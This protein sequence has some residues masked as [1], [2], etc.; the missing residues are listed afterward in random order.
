MLKTIAKTGLAALTLAGFISTAQATGLGSGDGS[1]NGVYVGGHAGGAWGDADVTS[2]AVIF[3]PGILGNDTQDSFDMDGWLAGAHVGANVQSGAWV[4]GGELSLSAAGIDGSKTPCAT[5]TFAAN[6]QS[7]TIDHPCKKDDEW[8]ALAM[9][10]FGYAPGNWMGYLTA[11]VAVVGAQTTN[12]QTQSDGQIT[13][14]PF[15]FIA[16]SGTDVGFAI[17]GG[18]EV[19]L[20][21]G[22][23]AGVEYIHAEFD[24]MSS[25]DDGVRFDYSQDLD[26]VRARLSLMLDSCCEG[27]AAAP[28]KT[29]FA[30]VLPATGT[31]WGGVYFGGNVGYGWSDTT[32]KVIGFRDDGSVTKDNFDLEGWLGGVHLGA[33]VQRGNFVLGTEISLSAA[34]IDGKTDSCEGFSFPGEV[35]VNVS[36]SKQDEWLLLAMSRFGYAPGNWMAYVTYGL[37]VVGYQT[38]SLQDLDLPQQGINFSNVPLNSSVNTD[39]GFAIGGGA[40]VKIGNN[41]VAG[42]EYIHAQFDDARSGGGELVYEYEQDLDIVRARLSMMLN[43][44]CEAAAPSKTNMASAAAPGGWA[45]FYFGSHAGLGW[46][47]TDVSEDDFDEAGTQTI[48]DSFELDGYLAGVHMGGNVQS[49]A[50]V[51]G[52]E[53]SVSGGKIDGSKGP[54]CFSDFR[55]DSFECKKE[56]KWLALAMGRLGYA[57]GAWMGYV[58]AGAAVIGF[59]TDT[60]D[61][62]DPQ[63]AGADTDLGYAVGGGVEVEV[64]PNVIAGVEYIHAKFD[65]ATDGSG[66]VLTW[67]QDLDLV[68]GRLS[69]KFGGCCG[70][71]PAHVPFK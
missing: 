10:R 38:D 26:I 53:L 69:Y 30:G 42:I 7:F 71:A 21:G 13:F 31:A 49:G 57:P 41:I 20:G 70:A 25:G 52:G 50:F 15:P 18:A 47:D 63:S 37:A 29:G 23:I 32:S 4:I 33:N 3:G 24:D 62:G 40:E 55:D 60:V 22:L 9:G 59:Q 1:W 64:M 34:E 11:G 27:V 54:D 2:D 14:G 16:E 66:P 58:T 46:A 44:C 56:D 45:G 68:R 43:E 65:G 8:L 48:S 12:E 17:G 19:Q 28:S 36:C 61:D 6:G 5:Q 51:L 67:E 39:A 35:T